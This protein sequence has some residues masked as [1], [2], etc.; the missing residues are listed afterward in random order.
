MDAL[1]ENTPKIY[2]IEEYLSMEEKLLE[3]HHFINGKIIAMPVTRPI[4]NLI[5]ANII[6]QR[7]FRIY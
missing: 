4:H 1:L 2:T 5:S 7:V 6:K 3:K